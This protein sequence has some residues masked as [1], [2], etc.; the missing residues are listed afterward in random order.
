[1]KKEIH[2]EKKPS[3]G[4]DRYYANC[5]ISRVMLKLMKRAVFTDPEVEC[6]KSEGIEV[7]VK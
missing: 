7:H 6:I 4:R 3:Y 5:D 1:M 2:L